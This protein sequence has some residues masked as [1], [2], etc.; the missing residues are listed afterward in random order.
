MDYLG[1]VIFGEGVKVDPRKISVMIEWPLPINLKVLRGFL[2]LTG[3]YRKFIKNYGLI[4]T[5]LTALLRKN[6]FVWS[7]AASRSFEELKSVVTQPPVLSLSDFSQKFTIECDASGLGI[8]AVL[9]QGGKPIA[10]MSKALKGRTLHLSTYEKE[11]L[12]VVTTV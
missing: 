3:Y 2:G 1:H 6:A 5:L 9:M 4:A 10:Y 7:E 8:G 11:L 12:A